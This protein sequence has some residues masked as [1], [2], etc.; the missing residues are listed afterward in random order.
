MILVTM[1]LCI[2]GCDADLL[3]EADD[4]PEEYVTDDYHEEPEVI[5]YVS[6]SEELIK[7]EAD[8]AKGFYFP[9]YLYVPNLHIPEDH[10]IYLL[11]ITNNTVIGHEDL[12][13]HDDAARKKVVS[14]KG[15]LFAR[16]LGVPL[17]VPVFPRQWGLACTQALL[18][19]T[20]VER[21]GPLARADLQLIAMIRDAHSILENLG[22][23][24]QKQILMNGFSTSAQAALRFTLLHPNMVKAVA[25]GGMSSLL[26]LPV[27]E[28]AGERL[29]YCIGI[30]DLEELTGIVFDMDAFKEV[31]KFFYMGATDDKEANDI[32]IHPTFERKDAELIWKITDKYM[33]ARWEKYQQIYKEIDIPTQFVTY[34]GVGHTITNEM[35]TDVIEFF[36]ENAGEGLY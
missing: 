34:E 29:R 8:P 26:V 15:N 21:S 19:H 5:E 4:M 10:C 12:Q 16:R 6:F 25:A 35:I 11:V 28:W 1:L 9:Y 17:L 36:V 3:E 13:V 2:T 7:V 32:T 24:M 14:G 27:E 20:L 23:N 22:F 30:A 18:R 31:D 33:P